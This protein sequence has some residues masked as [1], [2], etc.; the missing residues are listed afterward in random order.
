MYMPFSICLT[1]V[2]PANFFALSWLFMPEQLLHRLVVWCQYQFHS[3][4]F[5]GLRHVICSLDPVIHLVMIPVAF[6]MSG[7]SGFDGVVSSH[8]I[9]RIEIGRVSFREGYK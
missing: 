5:I 6:N 7:L 2:S 1:D 3:I 4:I 8:Q 9:N